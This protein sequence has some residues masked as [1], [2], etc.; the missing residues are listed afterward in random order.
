MSKEPSVM[1]IVLIL[2]ICLST[3]SC[4]NQKKIILDEFVELHKHIVA[5]DHTYIDKHLTPKSS[6]FVEKLISLEKL[7]L[8]DILDLGEEYRFKDFLF[9]YYF[10]YKKELDNNN[11]SESFYN[12][13][14]LESVPLFSAHDLYKVNEKLSR[15]KPEIF[16]AIYR[17]FYENNYLHWVKLTP[18][19]SSIK[20]DLLYTLELFNKQPKKL[21]DYAFK[22]WNKGTKLEF[23][24]ALSKMNDYHGF[25]YDALNYSRNRQIDFLN[26]ALKNQE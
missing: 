4:T 6:E 24:E 21:N 3:T 22:N 2:F 16:I 1:R 26:E 13:L 14:A 17:D 10:K 8:T 11:T 5:G 19:E 25:D 9:N 7:T 23:Y 18:D 20:Y 12:F 15:I